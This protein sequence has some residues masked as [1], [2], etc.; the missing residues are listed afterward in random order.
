MTAFT[1][2]AIVWEALLIGSVERLRED[3]TFNTLN[4]PEDEEL[5]T[6]SRF[7]VITFLSANKKQTFKMIIYTGK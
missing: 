2:F 3:I 6:T 5:F 7:A 1:H 4:Y